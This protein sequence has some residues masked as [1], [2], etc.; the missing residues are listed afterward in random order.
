MPKDWIP[1]SGWPITRAELDDHYRKAHQYLNLGPFEYDLDFWKSEYARFPDFEESNLVARLLQFSSPPVRFGTAYLN[2][3]ESTERIRVYLHANVT[4]LGLSKNG[5]RIE[6]LDIRS[7]GGRRGAAKASKYV[8]ACGGIE[9]PRLLLASN[10]VARNGVG[11]D[12]GLVGRFFME[13]PEAPC[14]RIFNYDARQMNDFGRLTTRSG[15]K[16]GAL[17]G[18][19]PAKQQSLQIGSGA[20]FI[21]MHR[22]ED[23]LPENAWAS[24][25]SVRRSIGKRKLPENLGSIL[26]LWLRDFDTLAGAAALKLRGI[27]P[28]RVDVI[29]VCEQVP[30]PGSRVVLSH[31]LDDFGNPLAN[32]DWQLTDFDRR[33][34]Y[35][36]MLLIGAEVNRLGLG[37]FQLE[38]WLRDETSTAWSP[39]LVGAWHHLGTTR[40]AASP[41]NGVVDG[42]CRVHGIDNLF[43]AGSSVFATGSYV[44]P[45]LTIVA[46]ASRLAEHLASIR[47]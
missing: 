9:N 19:S 20:G 4:R 30:N 47:R 12:R 43:V 22:V 35:K 11:N 14:A 18:A 32:L 3:L 24:Q 31:E 41:A 45:T 2:Q 1:M 25:L 37:R 33:T 36:T 21:N 46:L 39:E 23:D 26:S 42:N 5:A 13:H 27:E 7:L 10:D 29:S 34:Q 16:I 15:V 8:V 44:N 28:G 6:S 38:E 17:F 40:M